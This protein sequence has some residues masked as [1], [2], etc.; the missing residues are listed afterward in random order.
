MRTYIQTERHPQ[1]CCGNKPFGNPFG[2][3]RHRVSR[4]QLL[5]RQKIL[6]PCYNFEEGGC[7]SIYNQSL[8]ELPLHDSVIRWL[9]KLKGRIRSFGLPTLMNT[10]VLYLRMGCLKT[11]H[12][13]PWEQLGKVYIYN[14]RRVFHEKI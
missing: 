7:I 3:P 11:F 10:P 5:R 9:T 6:L 4:R 1:L 14:L 12:L 13:S 8:S 2:C